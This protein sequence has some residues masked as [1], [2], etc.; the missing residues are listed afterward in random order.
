MSRRAVSRRLVFRQAGPHVPLHQAVEG[1]DGQDFPVP[2]AAP[3]D[4]QLPQA[5][6]GGA[7]PEAFREGAPPE[8]FRGGGPPTAC[9]VATSMPSR[10]RSR[11][12]SL[13]RRSSRAC[14]SS[15]SET[16]AVRLP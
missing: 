8:A 5:F 15:T 12:P 1:P 16:P 6:R 9:T 11:V 3:V 4:G 14:A 10:A 2:R 13:R 7:P